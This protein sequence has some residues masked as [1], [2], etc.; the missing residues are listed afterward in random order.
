M[1][2]DED[3]RPLRRKSLGK[4]AH[5]SFGQFGI[6]AHLVACKFPAAGAEVAI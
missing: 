6:R 3:G 4:D 1:K 5:Y 2:P